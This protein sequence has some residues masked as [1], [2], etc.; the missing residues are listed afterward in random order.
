MPLDTVKNVDH[1]I[2][3]MWIRLDDKYGEPTKII[4]SIMKEVKRLRPLREGEISKFVHFADTRERSYR[5][6]ESL[7]L[8]REISNASTVSLVE[9]KLSQEMKLKWA[10]T[11][12]LS[13][14]NN[15]TTS[16]RYY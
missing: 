16:F 15:S 6:L 9:E 5:D 12:K 7:S 4:D 11:L 14:D 10:E 13:K 2:D 1:D 3:Q 8:E